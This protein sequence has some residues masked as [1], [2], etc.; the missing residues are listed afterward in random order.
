MT[1]SQLCDSRPLLLFYQN[2]SP[3][4]NYF[5][6]PAVYQMPYRSGGWGLDQEPIRDER[7]HENGMAVEE[8][9]S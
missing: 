3:K 4:A 2:P 8:A 5:S 7:H 1:P 9:I 6:E